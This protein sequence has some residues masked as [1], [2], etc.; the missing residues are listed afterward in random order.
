MPLNPSEG[1]A[2]YTDG[3]SYNVDRTGGWAFVAVDAFDGE[4]RGW[5]R[6]LD[7]TNNRMEMQAVI[8]GLYEL[9]L[10]HGACDVL[11]RSDSQ[12]VVL[13]CQNPARA[14]NVNHGE[15][16]ALD[17]SIAAHN[18]VE[19]EHVKGHDGDHFNEIVDG[20]AGKAR[21]GLL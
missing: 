13:G 11:V 17:S 8:E 6:E 3:S 4:I 19:F 14:R 12:Y 5:G 9:A 7:T 16:A 2:L 21:K 20:L 15:W 1:V 10:R 18:H